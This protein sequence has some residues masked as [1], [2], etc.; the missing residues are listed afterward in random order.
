MRW[1]EQSARVYRKEPETML[2]CGASTDDHPNHSFDLAEIVPS[3]EALEAEQL[4]LLAHIAN[5]EQRI[6]A[7]GATIQRLQALPGYQ[8]HISLL[9]NLRMALGTFDDSLVMARAV[10]VAEQ[11]SDAHTSAAGYLATLG[12]LANTSSPDAVNDRAGNR[13]C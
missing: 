9:D 7:L 8:P 1:L 10:L 13:D 5:N 4:K 2:P 6:A 3:L 12:I 11:L